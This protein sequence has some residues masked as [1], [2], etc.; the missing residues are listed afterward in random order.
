MQT[1]MPVTTDIFFLYFSVIN[2]ILS[3][4]IMKIEFIAM[5]L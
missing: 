1:V 5:Q 2:C 4:K 3:I